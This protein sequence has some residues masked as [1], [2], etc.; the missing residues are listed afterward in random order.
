M[1]NTTTT[2]KSV[3][4]T[5]IKFSPAIAILPV[6][7]KQTRW[8]GYAKSVYQI[9]ITPC[10]NRQEASNQIAKIQTA[11]DAGL[12]T[13]RAI[14]TKA[15]DVVE[16]K[17]VE[18]VHYAVVNIM[19]EVK[20]KSFIGTGKSAQMKAESLYKGNI[21]C[22]TADIANAIEFARKA[23]EL[24]NIEVP[25]TDNTPFED[26]C[27]GDGNYK[28]LDKDIEDGSYYV[29]EPIVFTGLTVKELRS[30]AK[31]LGVE[32]GSCKLKALIIAKLDLAVNVV[33]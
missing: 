4:A 8:L 2:I 17:R 26:S 29:H 10:A 3:M 1:K 15:N 23:I 32:L 16:V 24:N 6:L 9:S 28:E 12:L 13:K 22:L 30:L 27:D 20:I 25:T 5:P 18:S 7:P 19:N 31:E 21:L 11:I 14:A 33:A